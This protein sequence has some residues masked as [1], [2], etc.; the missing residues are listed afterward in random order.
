MSPQEN[1]KC[2]DSVVSLQAT[3]GGEAKFMDAGKDFSGGP[4]VN[5]AGQLFWQG[6]ESTVTDGLGAI[7]GAGLSFSFN[8]ADSVLPTGI[9]ESFE[10]GTF[11]EAHGAALLGG[12]IRFDRSPGSTSVT[13]EIKG[14]VGVGLF[15]GE[16][17]T[18]NSVMATGPLGCFARTK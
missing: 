17:T 12:G 16:G 2:P 11:W 5:S 13:V 6:T 18:D 15:V 14:M 3:F 9:N 1:A 8:V 4:G 10:Q 7:L